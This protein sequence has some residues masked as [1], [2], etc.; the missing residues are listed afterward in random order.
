MFAMC[1]G[2]SGYKP[3]NL[4]TVTSKSAAVNIT[5][6]VNSHVF[7]MF[8]NNNDPLFNYFLCRNIFETKKG[9]RHNIQT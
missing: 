1:E 5:S 6:H 2:S 4:I 8:K 9:K 3:V 7:H